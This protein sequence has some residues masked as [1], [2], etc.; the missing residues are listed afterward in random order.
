MSLTGGKVF[1]VQCANNENRQ[2]VVQ[3]IKALQT[4][5]AAGDAD[6]GEG[7]AGDAGVDIDIHEKFNTSE[8]KKIG[9]REDSRARRA[10]RA[11]RRAPRADRASCVFFRARARRRTTSSS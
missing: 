1:V 11:A 4:S 5:L 7:D 9:V 6:E 2:E 10:P 8:G 3:K